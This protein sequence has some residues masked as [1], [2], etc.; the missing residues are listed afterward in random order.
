MDSSSDE[1]DAGPPPAP[2][3]YAN[4]QPHK[5]VTFSDEDPPAKARLDFTSHT[6]EA[7]GEHQPAIPPAKRQRL[8]PQCARVAVA[9]RATYLK[10]CDK[11]DEDKRVVVFTM[12][13]GITNNGPRRYCVHGC[14]DE[15]GI[16]MQIGSCDFLSKDDPDNG[17]H[18]GYSELAGCV[19]EAAEI[20]NL[21]KEDANAFVVIVDP[22]GKNYAPFVAGLVKRLNKVLNP[23]AP[24]VT[25]GVRGPKSEWLRLAL[26][27][28]N[29]GKSESGVREAVCQYYQQ[30]TPKTAA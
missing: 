28:A 19:A 20:C 27:A 1:D 2:S 10:E 12:H 5:T 25:N 6:E 26:K 8:Q 15:S 11:Q 9:G 29:R 30:N 16:D 24:Q 17:E 22:W 13:S 7:G 3:K 21:L 4:P 14:K 23:G 18:F